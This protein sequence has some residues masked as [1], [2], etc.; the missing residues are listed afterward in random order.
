MDKNN[1]FKFYKV[2]HNMQMTR[3]DVKIS[4]FSV[5]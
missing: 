3:W 1:L 4:I 5:T 2:L